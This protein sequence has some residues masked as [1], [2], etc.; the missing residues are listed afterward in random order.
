MPLPF[1]TFKLSIR[2]NSMGKECHSNPNSVS[3]R[4]RSTFLCLFRN[5]E[6]YVGY[7]I[8]GIVHTYVLTKIR[9]DNNDFTILFGLECEK[10]KNL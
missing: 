7:N 9:K 1:T 3:S 4:V 6:N 10:D 5:V 2:N 8:I